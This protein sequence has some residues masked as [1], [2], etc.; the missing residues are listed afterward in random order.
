MVLERRVGA[1]HPGGPT[2]RGTLRN[3][4]MSKASHRAIVISL[5]DWL[6]PRVRKPA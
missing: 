3:Q 4:S 1:R 5:P 2:L 6:M